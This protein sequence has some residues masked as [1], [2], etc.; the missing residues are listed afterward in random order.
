[1][2]KGKARRVNRYS[3]EFKIT[4]IKLS[5]MPGTLIKD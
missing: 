2:G 5:D 4:A 1:M 3:S